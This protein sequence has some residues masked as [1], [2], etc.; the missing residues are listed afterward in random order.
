MSGARL[1]ASWWRQCTCILF[2]S[3]HAYLKYI[4]ET[5]LRQYKLHKMKIECTP[6]ALP[7]WPARCR[8]YLLGDWLRLI[9]WSWSSGDDDDSLY[10]RISRGQAHLVSGIYVNRTFLRSS[11][12]S[13]GSKARLL[14]TTADTIQI[15][16]NPTSQK[17]Y[18]YPDIYSGFAMTLV[19]S[20]C[21]LKC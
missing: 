21:I 20:E 1:S 8:T 11:S 19:S 3:L 5:K 15:F 6:D 2:L 10:R 17:F 4:N 12:K 18:C 14:L 9:D 16:D 7:M 13:S